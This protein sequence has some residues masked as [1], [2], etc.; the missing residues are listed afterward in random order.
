M[1]HLYH[2][3]AMVF[4]GTK[5][6]GGGNLDCSVVVLK[7]VLHDEFLSKNANIT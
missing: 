2:K 1:D 3:D 5:F 6:T 4:S 7:S